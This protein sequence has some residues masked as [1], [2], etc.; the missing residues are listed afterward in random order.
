MIADTIA[1]A[2]P[3]NVPN[4]IAWLNLVLLFNWINSSINVKIKIPIG[5]CTTKGWKCPMNSVIMQL[6]YVS[7]FLTHR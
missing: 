3:M 7:H 1:N 6:N 5:K 2:V 4:K